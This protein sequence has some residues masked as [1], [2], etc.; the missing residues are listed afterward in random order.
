[1]FSVLQNTL[2]I[3]RLLPKN[4]VY[5][6]IANKCFE[7]GCCHRCTLRF[8]GIRDSQAHLSLETKS[9]SLSCLKASADNHTPISRRKAVKKGLE[10][11]EWKIEPLEDE[12]AKETIDI[13]PSCLG[14]L[15]IDQGQLSSKAWELF[16]SSRFQIPSPTFNL[17]IRLPFQ[18]PIRQQATVHALMLQVEE[19]LQGAIPTPVEVKEI[20]KILVRDSFASVS[21]LTF[22]VKSPLAY[23]LHL[24]H[25]DTRNEFEFLTALPHAKFQVKKSKKRGRTIFEGASMEKVARAVGLVSASDFADAQMIPPPKL[26]NCPQMHLQSFVQ[27]PIFLSGRYC[28][29]KRHISNSQWILNGQRMTED[30]IEELIGEFLTIHFGNKS[31]KFSSAGREDSD[32]LMLGIGRPFYFELI[33]P[34]KGM[35]SLQEL[36]LLEQKINDQVDA[37][38]KVF[39]LQICSKED[40]NVLKN[41][42]STKSKTYSY[43]LGS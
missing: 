18:L 1:M 31:Y 21:S 30:S 34:L 2:A 38:I 15:Q 6:I 35:E 11:K 13:C 37:K 23:H 14:L 32:V 4:P 10:E 25:E 40:T 26:V 24:E 42:A 19:K 12:P 36:L 9:I 33:E 7:M 43:E 16:Q 8:L 29:L 28:K 20:F 17:S 3:S 39:D 27:A 22:D 41:S 5:E